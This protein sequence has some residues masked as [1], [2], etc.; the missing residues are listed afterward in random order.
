MLQI[1]IGL[2]VLIFMALFAIMSLPMMRSQSEQDE[3]H[4]PKNQA[5]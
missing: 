5:E 2:I 3:N 1:F 4:L